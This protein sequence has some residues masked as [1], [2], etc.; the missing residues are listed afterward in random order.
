VL[1]HL[2]EKLA[3]TNVINEAWLMLAGITLLAL[4]LIPYADHKRGDY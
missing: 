4:F 1:K 3:L 2:V